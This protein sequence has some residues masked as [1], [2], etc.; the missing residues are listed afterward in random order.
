MENKSIFSKNFQSVIQLVGEN[1]SLALALA[2]IDK[3]LN[4]TLTYVKFILTDDKPNANNMR[5]PKEEFPNLVVSGMYMPLK[6]AAGE[7]SEGHENTTPIGVIVY[8]KEDGDKIRGIAALWNSERPEDV[9]LIKER[10]A[11]GKSLDLSW[12]IGHYGYEEE[13]DGVQAL[14]GCI[15]LASTLVGIPAYMGRT[16]IT[17][18]ETSEKSEE[19]Q[20]VKE[21]L[22]LLQEEFNTLKTDYDTLVEAEKE[23]KDKV[24]ELESKQITSEVETELA[25]LREF[26]A[27]LEA[28]ELR[29]Q[30]LNEIKEKF[31]EAGIEKDETFFKENEERLLAI[32]EDE[33]GLLDFF[34]SQ[35]ASDDAAIEDDN[36][37]LNIEG[38]SREVLPN[39]KGKPTVGKTT[40]I[41]LARQLRD[42]KTK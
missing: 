26:K 15:L 36:T 28:T 30:K 4:P 6:M 10:Y 33:S 39:L 3:N 32:S 25:E 27:S 8:L 21:K 16:L 37:D 2:S 38:A 18:V 13:A 7:I 14:T 40:P 9:E 19:E 35:I 11:S 41:E 5:I 23:L 29:V 17:E 1:E 34:V 12:E 24:S 42:A 31:S 20:N 22:E